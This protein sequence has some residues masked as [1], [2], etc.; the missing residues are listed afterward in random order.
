MARL[1]AARQAA[2]GLLAIAWAGPAAAQSSVT[3]APAAPEAGFDLIVVGGIPGQAPEDFGKAV[4]QALPE[5]LTDSSTNFTAN[6]AYK[7][8]TNYRIVMVFHGDEVLD[9]QALCPAHDEVQAQPPAPP[10][11]LMQAT[12]VTAAFC[13]AGE[14]LSSAT[15][16][17]LGSVE[18]GQAGFRFL[19]SDVAKQLFPNGF[20]QMPGTSTTPVDSAEQP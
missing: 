20:D 4:A 17:M 6:P 15:D 10:E 14:T 18:P 5:R 3:V 13:E 9:T 12:H 1:S 8:D 11:D 16:R 19:V 2:A 7:A